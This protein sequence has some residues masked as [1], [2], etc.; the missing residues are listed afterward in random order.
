MHVAVEVLV[1]QLPILAAVG[2]FEHVAD[3][4]CDVHGLGILGVDG[5]IAHVRLNRGDRIGDRRYPGNVPNRIEPLPALR[6]IV[7]DENVD[8]FGSRIEG[9]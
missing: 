4:Q 6:F 7:A 9:I 8:G 3:L 5:D 1:E 2:G